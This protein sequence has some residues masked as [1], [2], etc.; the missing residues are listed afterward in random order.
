MEAQKVRIIAKALAHLEMAPGERLGAQGKRFTI[1][2]LS[3]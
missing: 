3:G 2:S 1:K